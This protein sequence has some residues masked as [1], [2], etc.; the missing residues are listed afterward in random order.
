MN[1]APIEKEIKNS[2]EYQTV[3]YVCEFDTSWILFLF[4]LFQQGVRLTYFEVT[5]M[6]QV[7]RKIF[8]SK[9]A[10]YIRNVAS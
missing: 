5:N 2:K 4:F 3:M 7:N 9:V 1:L 10:T 8:W 6:I